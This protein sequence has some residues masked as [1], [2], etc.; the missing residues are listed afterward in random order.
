MPKLRKP[1]TLRLLTQ[2]IL[3]LFLS[4]MTAWASE[5]QG[6]S[7]QGTN[8]FAPVSTPAKS[9]ADLSVFI[10]VITGVIFVVVFALLAYSVIKFRGRAMDSGREPAQVYGSTQIELAWT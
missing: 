2:T 6:S 3:L 5:P 8:I 10:L 9:I 7:F 1:A 4:A